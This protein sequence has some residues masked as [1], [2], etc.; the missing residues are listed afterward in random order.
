MLMLIC[1]SFIEKETFHFFTNFDHFMF[2]A[3]LIALLP[4]DPLTNNTILHIYFSAA[5]NKPGF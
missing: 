5:S 1:R 2:P 4:S 3:H